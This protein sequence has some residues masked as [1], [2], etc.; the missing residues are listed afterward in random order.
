[1]INKQ[2]IFQEIE[3]ISEQELVKILNLIRHYND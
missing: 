2:L 3:G 1:M